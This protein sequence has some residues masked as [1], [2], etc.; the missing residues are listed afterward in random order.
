MIDKRGLQSLQDTATTAGGV[1]G[2]EVPD[3][4]RRYIYKIKTANQYNGANQLELG[5]SKD[6]GTTH[7]TLDY[8]DHTVQHD[9]W[10]DPDTLHED[11]LPIY[12]IPGGNKTYVITDNGDVECYFE[13]EDSE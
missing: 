9:M 8:I 4:M 6:G 5:Y 13:Y 1:I 12:I 11:S 3:N 10:N 7:T 2:T